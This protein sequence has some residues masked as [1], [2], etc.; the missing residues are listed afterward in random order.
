MIAVRES[1]AQV[2]ASATKN[3]SQSQTSATDPPAASS[4]SDLVH[5]SNATLVGEGAVRALAVI[6][7][8]T[9]SEQYKPSIPFEKLADLD[10]NQE[11]S[12]RAWSWNAG[13]H[14]SQIETHHILRGC[15]GYHMTEA[16]TTAYRASTEEKIG[17]F[18]TRFACSLLRSVSFFST[19]L[20]H[21]SR[22]FSELR[23]ILNSLSSRCRCHNALFAYL[24][25]S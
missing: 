23:S 4:P 9:L 22:C 18:I 12:D 16:Q 19:F 11:W 8:E 14:E 10:S 6:C 20:S 5:V 17:I 2:F 24:E 25:L 15:K 13:Q 1:E 7:F 3:A 21:S